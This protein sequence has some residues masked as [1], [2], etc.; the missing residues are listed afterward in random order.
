MA[1]RALALMV[2]RANSRVAFG[3]P[4]ADQGTVRELIA[5][6]RID[7][8]QARL[9]VYKT[10]W[11]IDRHGA[12]GAKTEIAAIKVAAPAIATAVIDRAIEVFG[13]AGVS[14]NTPLAYFYAWRA[15]CASSTG[16][17]PYIAARSRVRSSSAFR[18]TSVERRR[19]SRHSG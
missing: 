6:S 3:K 12:R 16:P 14:D 19:R 10:A 17:T 15:C 11:L 7:I 9:L 18:R 2:A 1:E 8:D 4:L 13:G 5:Q